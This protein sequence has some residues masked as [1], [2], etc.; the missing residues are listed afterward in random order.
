[1]AT[2]PR[3][4]QAVA[5]SLAETADPRDALARALRAIGESLG[6][7]LGA[8]WEPAPERPEALRCVETW[9]ADGA[10]D[11]GVRGASREHRARR[12]RG[13]AGAR[14]AER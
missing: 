6:W 1:M 9:S 11:G 13:T 5:R 12:G 8:V 2:L 7:R 3:T 4:E 14:V 10:A